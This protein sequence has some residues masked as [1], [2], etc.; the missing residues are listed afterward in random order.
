[1]AIIP[2]SLSKIGIKTHFLCYAS[3]F[4]KRLLP[5]VN[6]FCYNV[7]YLLID[8][9]KTKEL[10]TRFLSLNKFNIFSFYNQ[11][12]CKPNNTNLEV[13]IREILTQ[14]NLNH[15]IQQIFLLTHPRILG[16]VFNPVS[17]W[18]CLNEKEEL[19][20][21]LAEVNNTFGEN[22][23]YLIFNQ[24]HAPISSEQWIIAEKEFHVSPFFKVSG[25]YKFRFIFTKT[26]VAAYI[27]YFEKDSSKQLITNVVCAKE[28]LQ[29]KTLLKAFLTIPFLTLKLIVLIHWQALK[30]LFKKNKYIPKPIQ[31]NHNLTL[32]K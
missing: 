8:I 4:H 9:S 16:Y 18:F 17:F 7:F 21:V 2:N 30:L 3:V 6:E 24:N 27:D 26:K 29:D 25:S 1:M 32:S 15:K 13:W 31:K 5:S 10:E 12:H 19:I 23:N 20:A 22:H 28:N 14:N 11:D